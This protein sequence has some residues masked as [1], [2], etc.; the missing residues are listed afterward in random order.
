[1][2]A[3][4]VIRHP[5]DE[6]KGARWACRARK[7]RGPV[8]NASGLVPAFLRLGRTWLS[9]ST[10]GGIF[11]FLPWFARLVGLPNGRVPGDG[12]HICQPQLQLWELKQLQCIDDL[13]YVTTLREYHIMSVRVQSFKSVR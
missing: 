10:G 8:E 5:G 9:A 2:D 13:K 6:D 12:A 3:Y 11:L 1:M 4:R 7:Q